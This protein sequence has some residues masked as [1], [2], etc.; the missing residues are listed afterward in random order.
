[1]CFS[2][3]A[4]FASA[5]IV[6]AVG[7]ATVP[8]VR[9]PGE[10]P[11]ALLGVAFAGHQLVEGVVWLQLSGSGKSTMRS[12][13]V[14]LWLLFAW[15]LLPVLVPVAM[16]LV[17]P[18]DGRKRAMVALGFGGVV[19]GVTLAA[20]SF[21]GAVPARV[22]SS[23]LSYV[24]PAGPA[25][26]A[27]LP[28]LVVTCGP[29]LLSSHR[30]LRAWGVALTSAMGATAVL[31]NAGFASLWCWFAALLSVMVLAHFVRLRWRPPARRPARTSAPAS[32][33]VA[34]DDPD[35]PHRA[36]VR[37]PGTGNPP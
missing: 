33:I 2:S 24:V 12:P 15:G 18:D 16:A 21:L 28:Y 23:H 3:T 10:A 32:S 29:P 37:G 6:G 11:L 7:A 8:L 26:L 9:R 13:A 4:S 22:V 5:G 34:L 31:Q 30:A 20:A 27:I 25:K 36:D 1:V 35:P 19:V 17:E 14:E